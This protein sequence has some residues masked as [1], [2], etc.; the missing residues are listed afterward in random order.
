MG[1]WIAE[2]QDSRNGGG[3]EVKGNSIVKSLSR[4][5]LQ[6][7]ESPRIVARTIAF[8]LMSQIYAASFNMP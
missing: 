8:Y 7:T 4:A 6:V 5:P 2:V 1:Y 3:K